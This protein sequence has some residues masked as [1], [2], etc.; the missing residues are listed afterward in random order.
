MKKTILR[1]VMIAIIAILSVSIQAANDKVSD[2]ESGIF[3]GKAVSR[4]SH[5]AHY[6]DL[7]TQGRFFSTSDYGFV[8][9]GEYK[10]TGKNFG[11]QDH[12]VM[13]SILTRGQ[14]PVAGN[15]FTQKPTGQYMPW[16]SD[17]GK[18]LFGMVFE[19]PFK[20]IF[21][22]K[23]LGFKQ[24]DRLKDKMPLFNQA[25]IHWGGMVPKKGTWGAC[26]Q[27]ND[28]K[29][30]PIK[31]DNQKQIFEYTA[32]T[33]N[34]APTTIK[35]FYVGI[36]SV[37]KDK[38]DNFVEV[39]K[40]ALHMHNKNV[41]DNRMVVW[42]MDA[43]QA[44]YSIDKAGT[45]LGLHVA[46]MYF[47]RNS[48]RFD[49]KNCMLTD[50]APF[51][52][53]DGKRHYAVTESYPVKYNS[54]G[55]EYT[56]NYKLK[57]V[58]P[59]KKEVTLDVTTVFGVELN[60]TISF[61]LKASKLPANAKLGF[62]IFSKEKF[63]YNYLD[64]GVAAV[65]LKANPKKTF[66]TPFGPLGF[67]LKNSDKIILN[68][69]RSRVRF[70]FLAEKDALNV[71]ISLPM[72]PKG[73]VQP[74]MVSYKWCSSLANRG[75]KGVAPFK[76]EDLDLIEVIDLSNPNDPHKVFDIS[77]DPIILN[78]KKSGA[79]KL[80]KHFGLLNFINDP[81]KG[82]VP[83][84]KILGKNCRIINNLEST[85]FR[86]N[87]KTRFNPRTPYLIVVE[88]AFDKERRGEFHCVPLDQ[89]EQN[90]RPDGSL[91]TN[92]TPSGGFDTGKG[93]YPKKFMK[94]S[95]FVI[96]PN[97]YKC[98]EKTVISLL[99]SAELS[100]NR[101]GK[102]AN[103]KEERPEGPAIKKVWI[104]R[105][106]QMP[107]LPDLAPIAPK[108]SQQRHIAFTCETSSPW[109]L[110]QFPKL[111]GYNTM[112]TNHQA[113]GM[114]LHGAHSNVARPCGWTHSGSLL[115]QKW[116]FEVTEKLGLYEKTFL[117]S[118][119]ELGLEGTD[120]AGAFKNLGD[121]NGSK[122]SSVPL[123]PTDD[124]LKLISKALNKSLSVLTKYK[125]FYA[126]SIMA[127]PQYFFTKR[128]LDDFSKETGVLFQ[129]TP[130]QW[131]NIRTLLTGD[132]KT[133]N[134]WTKWSCNKRFK[135]LTWLLK[136]SRKY[137]SDTYLMLN[138]GWHQ[139]WMMAAYYG[140]AT[141]VA[142]FDKK[143][144]KTAGIKNFY[145]F[146]KFA[147]YDPELYADNDGFGFDMQGEETGFNSTFDFR[148]PSPYKKQW[149]P[150]LR[151]SFA[152]GLSIH[153]AQFDEGAK[154]LINWT[155]NFV[156][157]RTSFRRNMIEAL[158][159]ANAREYFMETYWMDPV[160]GRLDDL[161]IFAVPFQLLPFAKPADY[162]GKITDTAKQ[163]VIK[164][165][166]NRYGLMNAGRKETEVT[167]TLPAGM[168]SVVDLSNGVKQTLFCSK[169]KAG[170]YQVKIKMEQWTLK[171]LEVK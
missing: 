68:A 157:D 61:N 47:A 31:F 147:C 87:L 26:I 126:I 27:D 154:P 28:G 41:I 107:K 105:V 10:L 11:L 42:Q 5:A 45:I 79:K 49:L 90:F 146:L 77:N 159:Y 166:N 85:Y 16:I 156:K 4:F 130:V 113:P 53:L 38:K 140:P 36:K 97:T 70:D 63:F 62:E 160:R 149:F 89:T 92:P 152:G 162:T 108:S 99:F 9:G 15:N 117:S 167:L 161:R 30:I 148:W 158:L 52:E 8:P 103:R 116:L 71:A 122:H 50:L 13:H 39:R 93:P 6:K 60:K 170:E 83:L 58:L 29:L 43:Y 1:M 91:W 112:V 46:N 32:T 138:H 35:K 124:E 106:R 24:F 114:I 73:G 144:M 135:F 72:G 37:E 57:Y 34:F 78:W 64:K 101:P 66:K 84:K 120:Y 2:D 76:M 48:G 80:P 54:K 168:K 102:Y 14:D 128:N 118:L 55:R 75:D 164:K 96:R 133:L 98:S 69:V 65:V 141:V 125:S 86:F 134:A 169:N 127:A 59:N 17:G 119:L 129:S 51:I 163:A 88:H 100:W 20:S 171:T 123:V 132:K 153:A 109:L 121:Y 67:T 81:E 74:H 137:R 23:T 7:G 155:C 104:Y 139:N 56:L 44:A 21:H 82:K 3:F 12:V 33:F 95:V 19:K 143:L 151:D 22:R 131:E 115:G 110:F 40:I 25:V 94:E 111:Y 136:E 18:C 165:Y 142:N 145:D 150:K